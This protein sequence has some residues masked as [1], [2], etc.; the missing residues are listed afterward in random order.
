MREIADLAQSLD[1]ARENGQKNVAQR[2]LDSAAHDRS[3]APVIGR[4]A[5]H[6]KTACRFRVH[7][8]LF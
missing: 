1:R 2:E 4:R 5:K 7:A 8:V 3:S 6:K